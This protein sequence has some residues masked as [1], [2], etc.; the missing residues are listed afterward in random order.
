[1]AKLQHEYYTRCL[2]HLFL[3]VCGFR[4]LW[5]GPWDSRFQVNSLLPPGTQILIQPNNFNLLNLVITKHVR[6]VIM[7]SISIYDY[8][9]DMLAVSDSLYIPQLPRKSTKAEQPQISRQKGCPFLKLPYELRTHIYSY[10]LPGTSEHLFRGIIWT[11]ATAAIWATNQQI[12]RECINLIYGNSTFLIDVRYDKVEFLYQWILPQNPLVPKRV[13]NF[14]H[15]IALRNQ[16]LMR[17]F[18]VRIHQVDSYTGM[19][20]Y[21]YSNP[22][23]LFRG[24]RSQV[25]MLCSLLQEMHEIRE[26][27]ITYEGGDE[28]SHIF[29]PL[30]MDP[31]WH[32]KKTKKVTVKDPG[33]VNESLRKKLQEHLTDAYTKNSLMQLPLEL[34]EHV[35]RHALPHT[36]STGTGDD[37]VIRWVSGDISILSTCKQVN[38]EA[39]RVLYATNEFEFSWMLKYP[40]E[41]DWQKELSNCSDYK[42]RSES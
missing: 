6:P 31:F 8:A 32:L 20:K 2:G 24:L 29:L 23:L 13:F 16:P 12:Y 40:S 42:E 38:V 33:R 25:S 37:K 11:R 18:H 34:R 22:E 28:A 5:N 39:T 19:I 41:H 4:K 9:T 10:V 27:R 14:P 30:V 15:P 1:M 35:Y 3:C 26:F 7:N 17:K 36:L 21:N